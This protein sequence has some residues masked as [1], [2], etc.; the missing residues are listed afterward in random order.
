M[1]MRR[2]ISASS[3]TRRRRFSSALCCSA[4]AA[5]SLGSGGG[6]AASWFFTCASIRFCCSCRD[7]SWRR[8]SSSS[9]SPASFS[10]L[11]GSGVVARPFSVS[12][13]PAMDACAMALALSGFSLVLALTRIT[14]SGVS[15]N[16]RLKDSG[17]TMR[18]VNKAACTAMDTPRASCRVVKERRF[19]R[20]DYR[21]KRPLLQWAIRPHRQQSRWARRPAR[22]PPAPPQKRVRPRHPGVR[23]PCP[24]HP[25]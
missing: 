8:D 24:P 19:T 7:C 16:T 1:L 10:A 4:A 5:G 6:R 21:L 11:G 14:S 3:L 17:S 22:L 20:L 23:P 18:T 2:S 25:A 13:P 12:P 15:W 9:E